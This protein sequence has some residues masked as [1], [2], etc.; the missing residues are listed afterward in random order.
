MSECLRVLVYVI[1]I[2]VESFANPFFETFIKGLKILKRRLKSKSYF[3]YI[4]NYPF[5]NITVELK[6]KEKSILGVPT[7]H[8]NHLF[9]IL[10]TII[11]VHRIK[12]KRL[13]CRISNHIIRLPSTSLIIFF[14]KFLT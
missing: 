1:T 3:L 11:T 6:Q 2:S 10:K 4:P 8:L 14:T 12:V 7:Q 5:E 13:L 9:H